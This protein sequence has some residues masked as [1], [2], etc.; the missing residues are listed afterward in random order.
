M[1]DNLAYPGED[2]IKPGF[3]NDGSPSNNTYGDTHIL[4]FATACGIMNWDPN[5]N[6][7][8]PTN[9]TAA[10][11]WPTNANS[12]NRY[13]TTNNYA[14][15]ILTPPTNLPDRMGNIIRSTPASFNTNVQIPCTNHTTGTHAD[16]I[17]EC[18]SYLY[19]WCT[20]IGLDSNTIP[21]CAAATNTGYGVGYVEQASDG[22]KLGIIGKPGG[23]GG[24]S[25][26]NNQAANQLG[27][28]I[29]NGSICPAGWR[30]PVGQVNESFSP[31]R[32]NAYNEFAILNGA[33]ITAGETLSPNITN[34]D[35]NIQ[36]WQP[37]G[38][39][40]VVGSGHLQATYG[41]NN[42]SSLG[43]YL[44]SSLYSSSDSAYMSVSSVNIAGLTPGTGGGFGKYM[45][46]A[47]R[48]V[49]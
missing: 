40:S 13:V 49:L 3:N 41:L 43:S 46:M 39:F 23:I 24:E 21:T 27:V 2:P 6:I 14:G 25:K 34:L 36:N 48:C 17:S 11:A 7:T 31:N 4:T 26:G 28:A 44:S 18:L 45:G 9:C 29:S 5:T 8:T 30:L 10:S 35:I 33:M 12:S 20:A 37:V 47:V 22:P 32:Q 19:H 42:L 15:N 16:M 38:S 1:I